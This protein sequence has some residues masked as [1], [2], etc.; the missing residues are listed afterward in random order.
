MISFLE[1]NGPAR[2]RA[3]FS[4]SPVVGWLLGPQGQEAPPNDV[5]SLANTPPSPMA[6]CD[7]YGG[8]QNHFDSITRHGRSAKEATGSVRRVPEDPRRCALLR[9]LYNTCGYSNNYLE[10]QSAVDARQ[11]LESQQQENTSVQKVRHFPPS[12]KILNLMDKCRSSPNST[13]MRTSTNKSGRY[14]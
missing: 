10:L 2:G 11:K 14:C 4:R 8:D 9:L 7:P 6:A 13:R 3:M 12:L 1:W 5:T